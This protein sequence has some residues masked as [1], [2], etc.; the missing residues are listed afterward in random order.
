MVSEPRTAGEAGLNRLLNL[1]LEAAVQATGFDAATV[2]AMSGDEIAT[3]AATDERMQLIDLAQYDVMEGPCIDALTGDDPIYVEDI[4]AEDR[5]PLF[6]TA[7]EDAGVRTSLSLN[8]SA[9]S[10]E[11]S[12]ASL[13]LYAARR[14]RLTDDQIEQAKL[15]AGQLAAALGNISMYRA[16]ARLAE[17]LADS[18]RTRAG[19]EQAKGMLIAERGITAD[20]AFQVLRAESEETDVKLAAVAARFVKDRKEALGEYL[21]R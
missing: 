18:M 16:S 21:A 8:A 19:I 4:L 2:S 6:C 14:H 20:E 3:L 7:A 9:D 15:F 1:I 10:P 11:E 5:W 17:Q 12:A 13:N